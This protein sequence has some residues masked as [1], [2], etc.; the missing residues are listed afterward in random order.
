[1]KLLIP[2]LIAY[3]LLAGALVVG[4]VMVR[5]NTLAAM[6]N[7]QAQADWDE[8]RVAA[9][10]ETGESTPVRRTVPATAEPPTLVLMRDHFAAAVFGLLA[11][12]TALYVF[13]A[14]IVVGVVRQS[15]KSSF[16]EPSRTGIAEASQP[17]WQ[18]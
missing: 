3:L 11:P 5:E 12:A 1:M 15:R 17:D 7:P 2:I 9:A 13:T 6:S 16:Q 14:W 8:W 18:A 4:L 10:K